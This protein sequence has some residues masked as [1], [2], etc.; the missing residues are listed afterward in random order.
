[1]ASGHVRPHQL[2]HLRIDPGLD[3]LDEQALADLVQV[4]QQAPAQC[5]CRLTDEVFELDATERVVQTSL[6]HAEQLTDTH[7]TAA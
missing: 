2:T 4:A 5:R 6:N 7:V 1:M 3:S